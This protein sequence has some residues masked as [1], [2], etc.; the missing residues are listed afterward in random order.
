MKHLLAVSLLVAGIWILGD[1][2]SPIESRAEREAKE[3]IFRLIGKKKPKP[4][5]PNPKPVPRPAP[6]VMED[7]KPIDKIKPTPIYRIKPVP[8]PKPLPPPEKIVK[9]APVSPMPIYMPKPRPPVTILPV[10]PMPPIVK[11]KPVPPKLVLP[12][13]LIKS[14]FKGKIS[15]KE[16]LKQRH[17]NPE[18][19]R[20][21]QQPLRVLCR[22][23][24]EMLEIL[25][26]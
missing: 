6:P 12:V 21:L 9:P 3:K 14:K 16:M 13:W 19:R 10:E 17:S 20:Q 15:L 4:V 25:Q 8:V 26:H 24:L 23:V 22:I 1:E 5:A 11:P 18:F 2:K 7:I